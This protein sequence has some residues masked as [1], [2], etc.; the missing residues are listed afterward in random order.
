M[1]R[2]LILGYGKTYELRGM[3]FL[4]I[5][6]IYLLGCMV[7][8]FLYMF[9]IIYVPPNIFTIFILEIIFVGYYVLR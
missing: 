8:L 6:F 1:L 2:K 7:I 4:S 3:S 5:N 9:N